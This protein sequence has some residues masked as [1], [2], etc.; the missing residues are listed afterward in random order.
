MDKTDEAHHRWR[1][2][3]VLYNAT[4]Y[5]YRTSIRREAR[6]KVEEDETPQELFSKGYGSTETDEKRIQNG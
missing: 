5:L 2:N 3:S 4:S 6:Y 1:Y